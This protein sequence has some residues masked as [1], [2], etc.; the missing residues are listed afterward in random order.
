MKSIQV[1]ILLFVA[2]ICT[3]RGGTIRTSGEWNYTDQHAWEKV[4]GWYC[5]GVRQ[6]PINIRTTDVVIY[7]D[8]IDLTLWNFNQGYS[9]TFVNNGNTVNFT[10]ASGSPAALF[11]NH[12]GTYELQQFHIHW[13]DNVNSGAEHKVNGDTASGELHFV[14]KKTTGIGTTG[15]SY[16]VLAIFLNALDSLPMEGS[17]KVLYDNMPTA[18]QQS[19]L[20]AG[21]NLTEFLPESLNYYHYEGS[22]TTPPCSEVVQWFIVREPFYVPTSFVAK[23]RTI[24]SSTGGALTKNFRFLQPLNGRQVMMPPICYGDRRKAHK[25]D[26]L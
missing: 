11:Q 6:S 2:A 8:L 10:P 14:T 15:D 12:L 4:P 1:L 5:Y 9:G 23:L 18:D 20:V 21:V 7:H 19:N 16:A 25:R 17:I 26:Q 3:C 13:G 24:Q 22:L